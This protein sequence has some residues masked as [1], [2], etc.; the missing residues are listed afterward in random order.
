MSSNCDCTQCENWE[1]CEIKMVIHNPITSLL[2]DTEDLDNGYAEVSLKG[3]TMNNFVASENYKIKKGD[4]IGQLIL[5]K[6]EGW[7]L[8]SEYTKDE[9]RT[10]GFGSTGK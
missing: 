6:H 2:V 10:G 4:K 1:S 3:A 8:P 5:C 9:E 7:L